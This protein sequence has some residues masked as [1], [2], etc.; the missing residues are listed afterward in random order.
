LKYSPFKTKNDLFAQFDKIDGSAGTLVVIFNMLLN[1][2]GKPY[3]QIDREKNDI[4]I[5]KFLYDDD[6]EIKELGLLVVF[7]S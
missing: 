2:I 4:F 6:E 3:L 7:F 1:D 5:P